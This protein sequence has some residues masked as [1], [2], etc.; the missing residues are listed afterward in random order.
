MI[1]YWTV[2]LVFTIGAQA[3]E[4]LLY[5]LPDDIRESFYRDER[6]GDPV[7]SRE[8]RYPYT[9]I[10]LP[11]QITYVGSRYRPDGYYNTAAFS[12][13]GDLREAEIALT[14][15]LY[16]GG[17]H[18][19][20]YKQR[21]GFKTE[22]EN[23]FCH[24]ATGIYTLRT[25]TIGANQYITLGRSDHHCPQPPDTAYLERMGLMLYLPQLTVPDTATNI[26]DGSVRQSPKGEFST[27]IAGI[28]FTS[29]EDVNSIYSHFRAQLIRQEWNE[30]HVSEGAES[31]QSGWSRRLESQEP[32][33]GRLVI[34][35]ERNGHYL[36]V[37]HL[38]QRTSAGQ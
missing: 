25:K 28:S 17:W 19:V 33:T 18:K 38:A 34:T 13:T 30:D 16:R 8:L 15:S 31:L 5:R 26:Q 2:L 20:S 37:F 32:L 9:E 35:V 10:N 4:N 22:R 36:M 23:R 27:V 6:A 24:P 7:V 29:D 14:Q 21:Y 12:V 1:R 11:E 3:E